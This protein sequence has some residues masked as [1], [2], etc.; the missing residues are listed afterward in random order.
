MKEVRKRI[1]SLIDPLWKTG[2]K[3]RREIYAAL[4]KVLGRE[5][6]TGELR[7]ME[8]AEKV[9]LAAHEIRSTP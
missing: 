7:T 3:P 1:H 4:T 9:L 8:E 5:Y 6:H 2:F